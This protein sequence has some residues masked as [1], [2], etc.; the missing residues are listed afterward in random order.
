MTRI[1]NFA[2]GGAAVRCPYWLT[3]VDIMGKRGCLPGLEKRCE[4]L[5]NIDV[6]VVG[7]T[8]TK[9]DGRRKEVTEYAG[10]VALH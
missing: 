9:K 6:G 1:I 10:M 7:C 4:H 3:D 2:N 5:S 8:W